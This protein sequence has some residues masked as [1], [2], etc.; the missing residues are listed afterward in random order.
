MYT[1][2]KTE[3]PKEKY[4]EKI[5]CSA[6]SADGLTL[7]FGTVNGTISFRSRNL[8]EK[9]TPLLIKALIKNG[10]SGLVYVVES[11][12]SRTSKYIFTSGLLGSKFLLFYYRG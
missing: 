1:P 6:W 9:V 12:N 7:A 11:D 3:I 5:I 4:K 2:G 10:G 8:D